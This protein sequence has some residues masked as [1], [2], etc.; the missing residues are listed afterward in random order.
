MRAELR[1]LFS[2]DVD[3]LRSY[4]SAESFRVTVRAMIG[5]KGEPGEESFDFDVCSPAW[6]ADELGRRPLIA[7]RC[8]LFMA[9]FSY[10]AVEGYVLQQIA[11]ATG[12]DWGEVAAKLSR[13]A[14]WE[15]EDYVV[16]PG[17]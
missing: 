13:W 15:F 16:S 9:Q 2:S 5:P 12:D 11:G 6:L 1:S 10:E 3:D 14:Y 17:C 7:G 4:S 8:R